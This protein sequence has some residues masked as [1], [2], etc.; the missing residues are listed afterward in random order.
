MTLLAALLLAPVVQEAPSVDLSAEEIVV[1]ARQERMRVSLR[2][3][4]KRR[5]RGCAI[6]KTSGDAA[7]DRAVCETAVACARTVPAES[8]EA[9]RACARPK[10]LAFARAQIDQEEQE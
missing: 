2:Y 3:D 6:A 5:V 9:I 7:F 10:L 8:A 1:Q 4:R